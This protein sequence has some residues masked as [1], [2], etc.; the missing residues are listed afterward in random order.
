MNYDENPIMLAIEGA[1]IA[2]VGACIIWLLAFMQ[3]R[4]AL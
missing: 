4:C 2:G 1:A 3:H